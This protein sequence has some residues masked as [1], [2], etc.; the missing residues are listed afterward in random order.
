MYICLL[1][2]HVCLFFIIRNDGSIKMK[3]D[4]L[5]REIKLNEYTGLTFCIFLI[6][7][8]FGVTV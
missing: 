1:I 6:V 2:V 7:F 8:T 3:T 5:R 4:I